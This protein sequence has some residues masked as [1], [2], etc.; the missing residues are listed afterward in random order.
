MYIVR[1]DSHPS[2]DFSGINKDTY[3]RLF[4][5]EINTKLRMNS[6]L[7]HVLKINDFY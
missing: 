7:Q 2:I 6:M 4:P 1:F 5:Y 3:K